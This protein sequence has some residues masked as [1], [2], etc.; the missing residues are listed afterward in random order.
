M[1]PGGTVASPDPI[2][3]LSIEG[4]FIA[5]GETIRLSLNIE[6]PSEPVVEQALASF[7]GGVQSRGAQ[8]RSSE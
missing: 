3:H 7:W 8:S 4:E 1:A 5:D 2:P 6:N